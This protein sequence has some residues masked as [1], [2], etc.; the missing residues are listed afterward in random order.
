MHEKNFSSWKSSTMNAIFHF[1]RIM[2]PVS[3]AFNYA[4]T[5]S[6][7]CE[8]T[9]CN[10]KCCLTKCNSFLRTENWKLLVDTSYEFPIALFNIVK[11][12]MHSNWMIYNHFMGIRWKAALFLTFNKVWFSFQNG[13][14]WENHQ[15]IWPIWI[16]LHATKIPKVKFEVQRKS[17]RIVSGK[18]FAYSIEKNGTTRLNK[19]M[20]RQNGATTGIDSV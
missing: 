12:L 20:F 19:Q 18:T 14:N 8:H 7:S 3:D 5:K 2:P 11:Y 6:P 10:A 1:R 4:E 16:L 17:F 9:G 15:S 13:K